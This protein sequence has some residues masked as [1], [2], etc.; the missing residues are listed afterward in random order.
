MS[1]NRNYLAESVFEFLE[2]N[3]KK[4]KSDIYDNMEGMTRQNFNTLMVHSRTPSPHLW[5]KFR[6]ALKQSR[7]EFWNAAMKFHDPIE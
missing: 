4:K 1:E 2:D 5:A 3:P 6:K 7:K